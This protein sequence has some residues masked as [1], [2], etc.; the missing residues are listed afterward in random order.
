MHLRGYFG[1]GGNGRNGLIY[2]LR[3]RPGIPNE[4]FEV[5]VLAMHS[6]KNTKN[7]DPWIK[8]AIGRLRDDEAIRAAVVDQV[9]E[10]FSP[11]AL[12]KGRTKG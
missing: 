6:T 5:C 8:T 11:K 10:I 9:K 2:R 12:N 7:T 3:V 4:Q 1:A